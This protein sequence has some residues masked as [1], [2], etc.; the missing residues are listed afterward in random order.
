MADNSGSVATDI[1]LAEQFAFLGQEENEI[2][3]SLIQ[4]IGRRKKVKSLSSKQAER[5]TDLQEKLQSASQKVESAVA[6]YNTEVSKLWNDL[7]LE[8]LNDYNNAVEQAKEFVKDR[9]EQMESQYED[10]S[11]KW[12]QSK[13]GDA[14]LE[15]INQW[16]EAATEIEEIDLIM[17][18]EVDPLDFPA[19]EAIDALSPEPSL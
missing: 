19:V 12:Q 17:P 8:S 7:V 14:F 5:L 10:G 13:R 9:R 1:K 4:N 16:E 11:E 3:F 18:V 15:W 2:L 6:E